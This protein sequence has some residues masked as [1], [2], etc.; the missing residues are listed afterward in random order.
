MLDHI[1]ED[2]EARY[3]RHAEMAAYIRDWAVKQGFEIFSE[4]G[5][6]SNTVVTVK[7]N[8]NINT[9]SWVKKAIA[10]GYRFV[11]GYGDLKGKT[12]RIAAMGEITLK[13]VKEFLGVITELLSE[14][15]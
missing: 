14:V 3:K 12:Y 10:R 7:N 6:H 11:D 9:A 1:L 8:L 5:Y 13:D 2:P 15:K 4:E